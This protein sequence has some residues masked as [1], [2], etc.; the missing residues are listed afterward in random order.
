[1]SKKRKIVLASL[2]KPVTDPR[3]FEKMGRSL[4]ETNKYE[5]NIIGFYAK[6]IPAY[7]NIRSHPIFRFDRLSLKRLLAP[8]KYGYF[9]L[10]LKPELIIVN[11]HDLLMVSIAYKILFGSRVVYDIQEN[12]QQNIIWSS[13]V[14]QPFRNMLASLVRW[15]ERLASRMIVHFFLAEKCYVNECSFINS[16]YTILENKARALPAAVQRK[17]KRETA[18]NHQPLRFIYSGTIAESYGIFDC[19]QL[20]ERWQRAAH[21]CQ[22]YI[23]GHCPRTD[24]LQKLQQKVAGKPY[25]T[26]NGGI[27]PVP[28]SAIQKALLQADFAFIAY[29]LNPSNQDCFPTRVWECLAYNVPMLMRKEHPWTPLLAAY[30][31]GIALDF[32]SPLSA[33]PFPEPSVFYQANPIPSSFYWEWEAKKLLSAVES[34]F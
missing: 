17:Q 10:K 19:I 9:L 15:K 20:V 1:M 8:L 34:L 25:I 23:I 7:P 4:A 21:A 18:S 29:Q 11:S 2:L 6:N 24:T 26:L 30:N 28:H 33:W 14:P 5:V 31:A 12:Y 13:N 27:E 3:M 22:L 16:P 32:Q